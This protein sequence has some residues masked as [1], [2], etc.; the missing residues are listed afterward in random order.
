LCVVSA[1]RAGALPPPLYGALL[2][3]AG[4]VLHDTFLH[5]LPGGAGGAHPAALL[6]DVPADA[7]DAVRRL[8]LRLL[9]P[10]LR[11]HARAHA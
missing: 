2:S 10:A 11:P 8:R 9:P 1:S 6:A 3:S 7:A 4:R 5:P